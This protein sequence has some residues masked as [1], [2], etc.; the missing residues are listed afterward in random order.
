MAIRPRVSMRVVIL[1]KA[2]NLSE[3][4]DLRAL[5]SAES[6]QRHAGTATIS[7]CG[8]YRYRLERIWNDALPPVH[9]IMLNPS[10]ADATQDDNTI[11]RVISFSQSWGYGSAIVLNLFAYR[12]P[13]PRLLQQASDPIGPRN[14]KHLAEISEPVVA[15]WGSHIFAQARA[16]EVLRFLPREIVCLGQNKNG[17]P[18]HPLYVGSAVVPI[19]YSNPNQ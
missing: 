2:K 4:R 3:A 16:E 12:T 5:A 9:W 17:S 6:V 18:K 10:T 14:D 1:N 13:H 19:L 15:A 11:R 8:Q 7:R